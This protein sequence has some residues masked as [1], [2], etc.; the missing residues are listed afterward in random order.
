MLSRSHLAMLQVSFQV[1]SRDVQMSRS[2]LAMLQVS[3]QV[4]RHVLS[5]SHPA[6]LQVLFRAPVSS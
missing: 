4:L 2:H 1:T 5:R 3:V 6:M